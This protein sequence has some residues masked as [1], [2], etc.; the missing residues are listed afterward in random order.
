MEFITLTV[1]NLYNTMQ[2]SLMPTYEK[3]YI[4]HDLI[5]SIKSCETHSSISTRNEDGKKVYLVKE[6]P[7]EI[8]KLIKEMT[9]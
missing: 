4:R 2:L 9:E 3:V 5:E 6:T 7:E 1:Y 8:I